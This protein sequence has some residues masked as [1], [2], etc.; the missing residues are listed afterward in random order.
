MDEADP[1]AKLEPS[2]ALVGEWT[3]EMTHPMVEDTVVRGQATY[4]WLEGGLY[5]IQRAVNDHRSYKGQDQRTLSSSRNAACHT[6]GTR[7]GVSGDVRPRRSFPREPFSR[8]RWEL[9][10]IG[11][12]CDRSTSWPH[13]SGYSLSQILRFRK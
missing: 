8:G 10:T 2:R 1:R 11:P 6:F 9:T 4:E 5:L 3:I 12:S 13:L 7:L